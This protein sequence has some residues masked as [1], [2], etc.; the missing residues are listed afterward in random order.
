MTMH[1]IEYQ[2]GLIRDSGSGQVFNIRD[3]KPATRSWTFEDET[4]QVVQPDV[5]MIVTGRYVRLKTNQPSAKLR[6]FV[7][8]HQ[9][10]DWC[11]LSGFSF[12]D[13]ETALGKRVARLEAALAHD[14]KIP[15]F[16]M[17]SR[18]FLVTPEKKLELEFD[19]KMIAT[20]VFEGS[21]RRPKPLLP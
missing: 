6:I 21:A 8:G 11:E 3:F 13:E 16:G 10:T 17:L 19:R 4:R 9:E 20:V 1:P 2:P 15:H 12:T 18:R 14:L 5:Q 7:D